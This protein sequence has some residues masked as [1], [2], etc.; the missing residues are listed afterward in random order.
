VIGLN[1]L[2]WTVVVLGASSVFVHLCTR[3]LR[4][5]FPVEP[6]PSLAP[7]RPFTGFEFVLG[8]VPLGVFLLGAWGFFYIVMWMGHGDL[9]LSNAL[10]YIGVVFLSMIAIQLLTARLCGK[11]FY[12]EYFRLGELHGG[13]SQRGAIIFVTTIGGGFLVAAA[14]FYFVDCLT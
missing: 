6:A 4:S 9:K 12:K 3:W 8:L 2:A 13:I 14:V 1:R 7:P 11:T 5:R 10:A